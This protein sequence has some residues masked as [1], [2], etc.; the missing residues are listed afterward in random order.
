MRGRLDSRFWVTGL[1]V[2]GCQQNDNW[3][4][5]ADGKKRRGKVTERLVSG[6]E[7]YRFTE[8]TKGPILTLLWRLE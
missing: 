3:R 5:I 4:K 1:L 6:L 7:Y 8:H 2:T